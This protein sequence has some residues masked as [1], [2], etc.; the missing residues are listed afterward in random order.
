VRALVFSFRVIGSGMAL[1]NAICAAIVSLDMFRV[2]IRCE[3]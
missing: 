2:A 3:L 1:I